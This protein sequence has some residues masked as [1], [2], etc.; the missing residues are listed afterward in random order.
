M[1]VPYQ[2]IYRH[3]LGQVY[4][5]GAT[6]TSYCTAGGEELLYVA[7]LAVFD[8]SLAAGPPTAFNAALFR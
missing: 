6:L 2:C 3:P 1:D 7:P 8:G 5:F 4:L